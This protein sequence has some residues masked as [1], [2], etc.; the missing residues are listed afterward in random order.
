[1]VTRG[2]AFA[3]LTGDSPSPS[4]T[5]LVFVLVIGLLLFLLLWATGERNA[6]SHESLGQGRAQKNTKIQKK[7]R[8]S[9]S[10][11]KEKKTERYMVR[12]IAGDGTL[13]R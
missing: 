4:F 5:F 13:S 6:Q 8:G 3:S 1:M 10:I 9:I 7:N 2:V 11:E 12:K